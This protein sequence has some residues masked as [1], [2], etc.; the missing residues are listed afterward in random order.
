MFYNIFVLN[1][2]INS[3]IILNYLLQA[4]RIIYF[5]TFFVL[6]TRVS[7]STNKS[8]LGGLDHDDYKYRKIGIIFCVIGGMLLLIG[9]GLR[10]LWISYLLGEPRQMIEGYQV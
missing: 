5:I 10:Y 1:L 3:N 7:G 4:C 6:V 8:P 2:V 9:L